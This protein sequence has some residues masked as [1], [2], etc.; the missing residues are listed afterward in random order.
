MG[1]VI[2]HIGVHKT[3]TSA[4]QVFLE[5]NAPALARQGFFYRPSIPEW[6]NHNPLADAFAPGRDVDGGRSHLRDLMEA[7]GDRTLLLSAEMLCE[8][9]VDVRRLLDVLDGWE[10]TAIAYIRHPCDIIVAAFS[11]A[12]RHYPLQHRRDINTLPLA[13]DPSQ[14]D[15]LQRFFTYADV[16]L[17][18]APYDRRQWKDGSLFADFL[19]MIGATPDGFDMSDRQVNRSLSHRAAEQLRRALAEGVSEASHRALKEQ[20]AKSDPV[21][22]AYPLTQATIDL[23]LSRMRQV[24]PAYRPFMRPGFSEDYLTEQRP[25]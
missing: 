6:P 17:V 12:V 9:Q 15:M 13:Y 18:L 2:L 10:K 16:P 11:E 7:A 4:I 19:G 20:L 5:R 25:Q 3:G 23:C 8:P 1:K 14:L 21:G 22:E 24:L